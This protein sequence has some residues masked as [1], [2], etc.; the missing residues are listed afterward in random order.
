MK[1]KN[2]TTPPN[3]SSEYD[4]DFS[5][6]PH[7]KYLR[8]VLQFNAI[9]RQFLQYFLPKEISDA[10][11]FDTLTQTE[12]SF[13]DEQL[14]EHFTDIC[15]SCLLKNKATKG[16][17]QTDLDIRIALI[18]EHK[19]SNPGYAAMLE[20]LLRYISNGWSNDQ[21]QNRPL[22]LTIPVVIYH[23]KQRMKKTG[24]KQVFG[25]VPVSFLGY[26]PSFDYFLVNIHD[27]VDD[28]PTT[29]EFLLLRKIFL[30]LKSSRSAILM[31]Q[32]YEEIINFAPNH[33]NRS[34]AIS[35]RRVTYL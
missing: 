16:K 17:K 21:R 28:I 2:S 15:Y 10:L 34:L 32:H 6:H 22:S 5:H 20:Q 31:E 33:S 26:V 3:L 35:V 30:A 4:I 23:G 19:S 24:P 25:H 14:S 27:V 1:K 8:H 7:D 9:T 18:F 11:D 13:L 12:D 29:M